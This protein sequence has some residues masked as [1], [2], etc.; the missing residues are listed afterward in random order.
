MAPYTDAGP[1]SSPLVV[2]A[3]KVLRFERRTTF[4][5]SHPKHPKPRPR[6]GRVQRCRE[7]QRQHAARL[8]RRQNPVVP[9]PRRGVIGIAFRL[10]LLADR[11][12]E[13]FLLHPRPLA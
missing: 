6:N 8:R 5:P 2:I 7:R 9:Q 4:D 1:M 13:F 10:V 12:L 11:L 3:W